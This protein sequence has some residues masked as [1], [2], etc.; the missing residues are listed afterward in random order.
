MG[1]Q[2]KARAVLGE[3]YTRRHV[4]AGV[5]EALSSEGWV[6]CGAGGKAGLVVLGPA[7][8]QGSIC[9]TWALP[10]AGEPSTRGT[11][12]PSVALGRTR[13]VWK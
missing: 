8:G 5:L 13:S 6:L 2:S 7:H 9:L 1:Q 4:V 12:A 3:S 10:G 11:C